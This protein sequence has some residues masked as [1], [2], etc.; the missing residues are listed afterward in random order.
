M[1]SQ[2]LSSFNDLEFNLSSESCQLPLKEHFL[3]NQQY[4]GAR[5]ACPSMVRR[6]DRG[7]AG[8]VAD[9]KVA[10]DLLATRTER[11]IVQAPPGPP[12]CIV[13]VLNVHGMCNQQ[14]IGL[15]RLP[16]QLPIMQLKHK[17]GGGI[18]C[19]ATHCIGSSEELGYADCY[20]VQANIT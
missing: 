6:V 14:S 5:D 4:L 2:R 12:I 15:G 3:G 19:R 18:M 1:Y 7:R 9:H 10:G 11:R 16:G 20:R 13:D 17:E 8:R